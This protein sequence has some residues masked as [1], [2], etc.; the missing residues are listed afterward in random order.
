M[1]YNR[2]ATKNASIMSFTTQYLET[3]NFKIFDI[4]GFEIPSFVNSYARSNL[5]FS[6]HPK[7]ASISVDITEIS[8][9]EP[10]KG[11]FENLWRYEDVQRRGYKIISFRIYDRKSKWLKRQRVVYKLCLLSE[12]PRGSLTY[13]SIP[14]LHWVVLDTKK[15]LIRLRGPNAGKSG[16]GPWLPIMEEN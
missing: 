4:N 7:I 6:I 15:K 11:N 8:S 5:S 12:S 13:R 2:Y 1:Y 16:R 3:K 14:Q 9:P 10:T